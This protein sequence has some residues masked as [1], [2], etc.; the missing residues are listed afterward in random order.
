MIGND[1]LPVFEQVRRACFTGKDTS[2]GGHKPLVVGGDCGRCG[3][4]RGGGWETIYEDT[5]AMTWLSTAFKIVLGIVDVL[6]QNLKGWQE[7]ADKRQAR[8]QSVTEADKVKKEIDE[9]IQ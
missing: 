8:K 3:Y 6:S 2:R 5:T 7:G 9:R 1:L 4:R